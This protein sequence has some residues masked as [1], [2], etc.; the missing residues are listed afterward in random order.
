VCM[1]NRCTGGKP[2]PHAAGPTALG[3]YSPH[4]DLH[5]FPCEGP[6]Q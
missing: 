3:P 6:R 2:S 5:A 1:L 4:D